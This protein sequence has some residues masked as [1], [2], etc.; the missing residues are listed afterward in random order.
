MN[1]KKNILTAA[2]IVV[3]SFLVIGFV[4]VSLMKS[5]EG[6]LEN[7]MFYSM[8]TYIEASG[9]NEARK[10]ARDV[11]ERLDNIF[12]S[13]DE[14]SELSKLN[15]SGKMPASKELLGAV[16]GVLALNK[17]YGDG[18]DITVGA[19]TKLWNIT[20]DDPKVPKDSDIKTALKTVG[21]NNIKVNGSEIT[22]SNG[23]QL[24]MGCAAKGAALDVIKDEFDKSGETHAIISA[25]SSS[26]LLYGEG[27]F[28][29]G[30]QSP[31]SE[32]IIGR[33]KTG[34]GFI[35]TSGG[36]HRY[37]E[38]DG[39]KY[40]HIIDTKTGSPTETDLSSVTVCCQSGLDSDFMS[41]LIF[42]G[43]TKKIK[44]Y[45]KNEDIKV[46]AIDKDKKIYKSEGL[47]FELTDESYS[48][49]DN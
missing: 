23:A 47:E 30:V 32:D 29:T 8:D 35:S 2:L 21:F 45:L 16:N 24:D 25:G 33:I 43:G 1:S 14:Q 22:L 5:S 9:S 38:I 19:L 15:K 44:D 36:Y 34:S 4:Y 6:Q 20:G 48:Y 10:T 26:I 12:D 31:D 11:F 27:K 40:T 41:T 17:K 13:H 18:A 28:N 42:A 7:T 39:K 3:L 37:A 49:A 46:L